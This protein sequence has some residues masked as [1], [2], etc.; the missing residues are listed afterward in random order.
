MSLVG[1]GNEKAGVRPQ[2]ITCLVNC[3]VVVGVWM[4]CDLKLTGKSG[5]SDEADAA[6]LLAAKCGNGGCDDL[7][8]GV[9]AAQE[10]L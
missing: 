10:C 5:A 7:S 4:H 8:E 9:T 6:V 3:Q 1:L 2:V